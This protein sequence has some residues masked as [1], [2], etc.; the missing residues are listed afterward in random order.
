[1]VYLTTALQYIHMLTTSVKYLLKRRFG[2]LT[3]AEER[4]Y[5]NISYSYCR[6]VWHAKVT[7]NHNLSEAKEP[8][9]YPV[10]LIV[11]WERDCIVSLFST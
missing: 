3:A 10:A 6:H 7:E 8:L 9:Q 4:V 1:M 2:Q 11:A 5:G